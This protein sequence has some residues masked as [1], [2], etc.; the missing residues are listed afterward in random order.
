MTFPTIKEVALDLRRINTNVESE[1]DKG[2]DVR[3]QLYPAGDWAI[4]VG[5]PDY[6]LDHLGYWGASSVPG[7][8]NGQVKRFNSTDLARDLISQVK[9]HY[10]EANS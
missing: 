5:L 9:D 4:R 3:L 8:V 7:V 6:D 1:P 2:C 10:Y